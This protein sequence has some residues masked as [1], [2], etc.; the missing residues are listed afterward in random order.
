MYDYRRFRASRRWLERMVGKGVFLVILG[1]SNCYLFSRDSALW[2]QPRVDRG[3]RV[4]DLYARLAVYAESRLHPQARCSCAGG[5]L[6]STLQTEDARLDRCFTRL[7][8]M[9]QST[10]RMSSTV[11]L[12]LI[13]AALF[14]L[15]FRGFYGDEI[16][17]EWLSDLSG[18]AFGAMATVMAVMVALGFVL[19]FIAIQLLTLGILAL[20]PALATWLGGFMANRSPI[21]DVGLKSNHMIRQ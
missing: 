15:V 17:V 5:Y 8:E 9:M 6:L 12:I 20:W 11:F 16:V 18:G 13:G 2:V 7:R 21:I 4:S 10:T 3:S 14:S 1:D 19:D